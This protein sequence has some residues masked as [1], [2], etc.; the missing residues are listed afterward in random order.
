MTTS[1][2]ANSAS[3][4]PRCA[5]S[6]SRMDAPGRVK[7]AVNAVSTVALTVIVRLGSVILA[8]VMDTRCAAVIGDSPKE[9]TL[10]LIMFGF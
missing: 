7:Y 10:P 1:P 6:N 3:C 2:L 8:T 9:C 5:N 4:S